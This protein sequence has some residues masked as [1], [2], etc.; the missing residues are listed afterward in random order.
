MPHHFP[1]IA[2]ALLAVITDSSLEACKL[3]ACMS[4]E[5]TAFAKELGFTW[6]VCK[7]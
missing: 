4:A 2:D 7:L 1:E 6:F 3:W 5:N